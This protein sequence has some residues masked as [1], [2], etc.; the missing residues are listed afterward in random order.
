MSNQLLT[1]KSTIS[2]WERAERLSAE[3]NLKLVEIEQLT[4]SPFELVFGHHDVTLADMRA[5]KPMVLR[6]DFASGAFDHRRK[7]G[8]GAGQAVAKACGLKGGRKLTILDATAGLGGDAF[9]LASLG[10]RVAMFER[11]VVAFSLLEDALRRAEQ[12]ESAEV[13]EI[14]DRMSLVA[15][16]SH[17]LF[18]T[19]DTLFEGMPPDVIYLDPMFPEKNKKALAKK[20]MQI[21][22]TL[23]GDDGDADLLLP[24]AQECATCRVVVKRSKSAPYLNGLAPNLTLAG[25][26]SRF[27]IYTKKKLPD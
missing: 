22:Q 25:K 2:S 21:F 16:D 1:V 13:L 20:E 4:D 19:A 5:K 27:D 26:S 11:S 6:V 18:S 7:F 17:Q 15:G 23:V 8:G 14:V 24:A 12:S 10:S 3:H 9:V